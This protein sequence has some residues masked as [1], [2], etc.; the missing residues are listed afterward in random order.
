MIQRVLVKKKKGFRVA[1]LEDENSEEPDYHTHGR[2]SIDI[3]MI[4]EWTKRVEE[5]VVIF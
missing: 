4:N 3:Y 2:T 5:S 1:M